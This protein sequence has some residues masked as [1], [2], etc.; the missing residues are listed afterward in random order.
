MNTPPV[1]VERRIGQRF[2]YLLPVSFREPATALEGLGFTQDVSSRGVFFVTDAPLQEGGE[3]ELTLT[4]PSE[5]TLG[6]TMRVRARGRIL[7]ILGPTPVA[8]NNSPAATSAEIKTRVE[9]KIGVSVVF[10]NYE[11]LA[12]LEESESGFA[13]VATLHSHEETEERPIHLSSPPGEG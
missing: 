8:Q 1:R 2:P 4:M 5:I 3:I 7:R 9:T 12:E 13:R 10:E 11:Y 6:D